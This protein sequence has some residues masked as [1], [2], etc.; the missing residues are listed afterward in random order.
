LQ[1]R[2]R[3]GKLTAANFPAL[4][5]MP[6]TLARS[7]ARADALPPSLRRR[8]VTFLFTRRVRFAGTGGIEFEELSAARAV[9]IMKNRKRVQNHLGTVHAAGMALLAETATG[10]VFGMNLADA[11]L[12]LLKSMHVD[13]VKRATGDLRAEA[14]LPV[15]QRARLAEEPKGDVVVPVRV[16]DAS[17]EEIVRCEMKWAWVPKKKT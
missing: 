10:A 15:E 11:S 3:V 8:L 17:G 16:T 4:A 1:A 2:N 14:S 7:L 9:L 13:Y 6:N 12:P 5:P